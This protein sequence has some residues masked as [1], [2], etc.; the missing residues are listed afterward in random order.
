MSRSRTRPRSTLAAVA[1]LAVLLLAAPGARAYHSATER[2]TDQTAYT[3]PRWDIRLGLWKAE[4]GAW[5]DLTVGT[6]LLPWLLRMG[7]LS[8]KYEILHRERWSVAGRASIFRLDLQRLN[9]DAPESYFTILPLEL[10]ISWRFAQRWILSS[11]A[12]YTKV[13]LTG[14]YDEDALQGAVA[15]TNLQ[16]AT[17]LLWQLGRVTALALHLRYLAF[18]DLSGSGVFVLHPSERLTVEIHGAASSGVTD[19]QHAF[20]VVPAFVWSWQTFNLRAGLGFGNYCVPGINSVLPV[21]GP[22]PDLDLYWVW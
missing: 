1:L 11:E 14:S 22:I 19:V 4:F 13:Q 2:V 18:Q 16:L 6:Y 20:A 9:E 10:A 3:L 5:H 21:R 12:I 15:V 8:L 17:T 7:N